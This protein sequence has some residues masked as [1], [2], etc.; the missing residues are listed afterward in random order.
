MNPKEILERE[1][2]K[3]AKVFLIVS[4]DSN[5]ACPKHFDSYSRSKKFQDLQC[6]L[7]KGLGVRN[8]A[9]ASKGRIDDFTNPSQYLNNETPGNLLN[10]NIMAHF[11]LSAGIKGGDLIVDCVISLRNGKY[12]VGPIR[13]VFEVIDSQGPQ[14]RDDTLGKYNIKA[15][16][17]DNL[18]ARKAI[19]RNYK[20]VS[21]KGV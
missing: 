11:P 15:L 6:E 8:S 19:T 5:F 7:C 9:Y 10:Y 14:M 17:G 1:I 16:D 12:E 2:D 3:W 18:T 13:E 4:M 21:Y 20:I